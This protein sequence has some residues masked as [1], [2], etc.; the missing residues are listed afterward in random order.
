M[1]MTVKELRQCVRPIG[2]KFTDAGIPM[3]D[4]VSA[5]LVLLAN[6]KPNE[7]FELVLIAKGKSRTS[8]D[9]V[10]TILSDTSLTVEDRKFLQ[11]LDNELQKSY[12]PVQVAKKANRAKSG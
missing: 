5:G 12:E 9:L 8:R 7:V 10:K 3:V 4:V 1:G 6:K 2:R 11:D